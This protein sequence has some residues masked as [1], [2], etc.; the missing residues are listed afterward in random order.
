MNKKKEIEIGQIAWIKPRVNSEDK[1]YGY[2]VKVSYSSYTKEKPQF[3]TICP[4]IS[5]IPEIPEHVKFDIG[6][7]VAYYHKGTT[8]DIMDG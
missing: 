8:W 7:P 6:I 1:Y 3:I 2:V 4:F 5:P